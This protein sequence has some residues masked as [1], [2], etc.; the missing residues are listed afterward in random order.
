MRT[1]GRKSRRRKTVRV[2]MHRF[3]KI[4]SMLE[5][6]NHGESIRGLCETF[7][8]SISVNRKLYL[9]LKEYV[10]ANPDLHADPTAQVFID[11]DPE[12]EFC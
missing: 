10:K 1:K 11:C 4:L 12:Y 5:N 3:A 8:K 6:N 9:S 7:D 2:D